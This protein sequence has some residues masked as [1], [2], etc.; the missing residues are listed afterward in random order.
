MSATDEQEEALLEVIVHVNNKENDCDK[1]LT[2]YCIIKHCD[3]CMAFVNV[4]FILLLIIG[5]I[6]GI[7]KIE[8][9]I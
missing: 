1:C 8:N 4:F 7:L 6:L 2:K 5:I 9:M 3:G